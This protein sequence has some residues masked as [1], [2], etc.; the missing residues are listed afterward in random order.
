MSGLFKVNDTIPNKISYYHIIL[1]M[2]TLPFDMFYSHVVLISFSLH[3]IINLKRESFKLLLKWRILILQ[4][5]FFISLLTVIYATNTSQGF[6]EV[7]KRSVIFL[8]PVLFF[9]NPLDLKKYRSQLFLSFSIICC[10]TIVYLYLDALITVRHYGLPL[11]ILFS[12][13]FTNHNF[14]EPINMHATFFSMQLALCLIYLISLFLK[15]QAL[16]VKL[17]YGACIGT[18][19]AGLI[20]LSSKSVCIPLAAIVTFVVPYF[21]LTGMA[22]SRFIYIAASLCILMAAGVLSSGTLRDRYITQLTEDLSTTNRP[23]LEDSRLSRWHVTIG[24]I[25]KKPILGYGAGSEMPLLHDNFFKNK[26]YS[27]FINNLNAHNQYLSF[28]LKSG[29]MGLLLYTGTLAFGIRISYQKRDLLFFSFMIIVVAVSFSENF[30]DVDK[31]I[32]YY[33]FFFPFF[34]FSGKQKTTTPKTKNQDNYLAALATKELV[35]PS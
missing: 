2:A 9:L 20:Q 26:L 14:S 5:V 28:L 17:F 4:S 8:F 22:R 31:G 24:L 23:H 7:G 11:S 35:T 29:I 12:S 33:A 3:T 25:A 32:I 19:I 1:L 15:E 30:L 34:L 27:S 10:V 6:N 21:L 18:L 13:A 16:K